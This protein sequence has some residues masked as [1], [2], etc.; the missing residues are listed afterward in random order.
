MVVEGGDVPGRIRARQ[1]VDRGKSL[2]RGGGSRQNAKC[3]GETQSCNAHSDSNRERKGGDG[4]ELPVSAQNAHGAECWV[5]IRQIAAREM[6]S[7]AFILDQNN[8][9]RP[10]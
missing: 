2:R 8:L 7:P 4:R 10:A 1:G 5:H 9:L 3:G 6:P